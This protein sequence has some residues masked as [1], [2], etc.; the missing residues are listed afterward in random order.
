MCSVVTAG[1]TAMLLRRSML[2]ATSPTEKHCN[3]GVDEQPNQ[4]FH[5]VDFLL[6]ITSQ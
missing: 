1:S 3:K 6:L 2:R 5:A 4:S